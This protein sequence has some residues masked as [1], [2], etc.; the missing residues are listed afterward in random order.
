MAQHCLP[1]VVLDQSD[2]GF[3]LVTYDGQEKWVEAHKVKVGDK[4]VKIKCLQVSQSTGSSRGAG[5][6]PCQK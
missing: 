6:S 5:E 2:N 4:Q 3:L 1:L